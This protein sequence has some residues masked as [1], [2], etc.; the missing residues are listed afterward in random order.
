MFLKSEMSQ[1]RLES[2]IREKADEEALWKHVEF[3][4]GVGEKFTGTPEEK[5]AI[6]YI[7]GCLGSYGVPVQV[8]EFEAYVSYPSHDRSRDADL[9]LLY[10]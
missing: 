9:L 4:C 10:P 5:K 3:L 2:T 8:H 7:V 1:K 6:D